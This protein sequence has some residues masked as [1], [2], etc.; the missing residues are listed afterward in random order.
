MLAHGPLDKAENSASLNVPVGHA[1]CWSP[2]EGAVWALSYNDRSCRNSPHGPESLVCDRQRGLES[3]LK[4]CWLD[5]LAY[6]PGGDVASWM[7]NEGKYRVWGRD[8]WKVP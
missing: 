7:E 6:P 8:F 1:A 4:E 2:R 3:C 5:Q